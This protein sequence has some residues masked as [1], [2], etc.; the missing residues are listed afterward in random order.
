M[1]VVDIGVPLIVFLLLAAVGM[2][3]TPA[4]FLQLRRAPRCLWVGVLAPVV[5][6]PLLALALVRVLRPG[7]DTAAG[8]L[9]VAACPIGGISNT[10]SYLAGASTG[11]S[12]FLTTT[13]SALAVVT[14]PAIS[15]AFERALDRPMGFAAPPALPLQLIVLVL[16]PV[17][18]GM[19]LRRRWPEWTAARRPAV[20]RAGFAALVLV[21]LLVVSADPA[22][23][24]RE[25]AE[26]VP[27]SVA[28]VTASFAIG[29]LAGIA[30]RA[31][32]PD[33]F[34]LA[35]EFATRNVA[36]AAA[37]AVTLLGRPAFAA[38]GAI[39]FL[40]E[41]PLMLAAVAWFRTRR[42]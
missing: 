34:T 10:Y 39:Y 7:A 17:G 8:L 5:L 36:I 23:F 19:W 14:I 25:A 30:V 32:A 35:A 12:V 1:T 40:I 2:D 22:A 31:S 38:F 15:W 13:S 37:I 42:S 16:V 18:I 20:Q 21:L 28:F 3:L 41:L 6:L 9:L 11:L 27:L 24:R 29:W 26:A 33:R 4:H